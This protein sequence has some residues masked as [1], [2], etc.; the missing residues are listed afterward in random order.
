MMTPCPQDAWFHGSCTQTRPQ[1]EG[2][3]AHLAE[4]QAA[5]NFLQ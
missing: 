4:H 5:E 2:H 3:E 1:C